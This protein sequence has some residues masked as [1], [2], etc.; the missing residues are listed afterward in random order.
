[1]NKQKLA[2]LGLGAMGGAM[3]ARLLERGHAVTVFN[4]SRDKA[5]ALVEAGAQVAGTPAEAVAG[6]PLIVVS[7]ADEA[8]V[9]QVLFGTGGAAA[10]AA[11]GTL[12]VDTSTV[13]P[14]YATSVAARLDAG[15]LRRLETCVVGNPR[16]AR[17]GELRIFVAGAASDLESARPLLGELG[18]QV[19]HVGG[20][21]M[22]ATVKLVFN[23]LLGVQLASLAEAVSLGVDAGLDRDTLLELLQ[24]SPFTSPVMSFRAPAM[25]QRRYQPPS[26]RLSLMGKD[27]AL[28]VDA[29]AAHGREVPVVAEAA[30]R[31][32][33][34]AATG[35]GDLDAAAI[36]ELQERAATTGAGAG[37]SR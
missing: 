27:L 17:N 10:A 16:H 7:L 31:F 20:P 24:Q 21:G 36:T 4:R 3:A 14:A 2:F 22:A 6:V 19:V 23:V 33:E 29:A 37:E 34:A 26:F 18:G 12:V 15:G 13:S 1:M 30:R 9:D 32:A 25:R 11:P 28:A 8:A 35:L 5:D